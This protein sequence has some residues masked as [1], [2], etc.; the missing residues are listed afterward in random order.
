MKKKMFR[1][2]CM[3]ALLLGL[4]S[5]GGNGKVTTERIDDCT[6]TIHLQGKGPLL[7]MPI[8]ESAD[9]LSIDMV[10]GDRHVPLAQVRLARHHADYY[11]PLTIPSGVEVLS[12][13][14][15]LGEAMFLDNMSFSNQFNQTAEDKYRP[16]YHFSPQTGWL[17]HL[18][19]A[20]SHDGTYQ[21]YFEHIPQGLKAE[22]IHW[23][24][25]ESAD[26]LT[27]QEKDELLFGDSIGEPL[28]GS[29][30]LD[31]QGNAGAGHNALI[32]LYSATH[33]QGDDR[34]Q[35]QCLAV[36]DPDGTHFNKLNTNPVLRTY[37]DIPDFRHPG[38]TR[39]RKGNIWEAVINCGEK[40]RIYSSEDLIN[41]NLECYI[42]DAADAEVV[43]YVVGEHL[44]SHPHVQGT[45]IPQYES[46]QMVELPTPQGNKW[47]L[48]CNLNGGPEAGSYLKC[49]IGD[50]NGR[51][52]V[53]QSH[54]PILPDA[55]HDFAST[56]LVQESDGRTLITG[57]LGSETYLD[58]LPSFPFCGQL[59]LPSELSLYETDEGRL[60]VQ[61]TPAR[62]LLQLRQDDKV[63]DDFILNSKHDFPNAFAECDGAFEVILTYDADP[64]ALA[65]LAL[66][67]VEGEQVE[68]QINALQSS[69]T[70][71]RSKSGWT[72][73]HMIQE[74]TQS[75][76]SKG[77]H[78]LRIFVDRSSIEMFIDGGKQVISQLL[79]PTSP[80]T[81]MQFTGQ[82]IRVS[83]MHVYQ[84][85]AK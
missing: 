85:A 36:L 78:E 32:A 19:G 31:K 37:D 82:G 75:G 71:N 22:N 45:R 43:S 53:S 40:L 11:A 59:A 25:A 4:L 30:V 2:L 7:I 48:L 63:F 65:S 76:L 73:E 68:L 29:V 46:A 51:K 3:T 14:G 13:S 33:G 27:W 6:A 23:S 9:P 34:R 74:S 70:L 8:E 67:N 77:P 83:N 56:M 21:I 69:L 1:S 41:W 79:F 81:G 60:K 38:V 17:G 20:V 64:Q 61:L 42:D 66:Y 26:L 84:L 18:A 49:F 12:I 55:G 72:D 35:E 44:P 28:G 5:C 54:Y 39:Y 15:N 62:E 24:M 58:G 52:F 16:V 10:N 57:L 47:L 50:F 80:Y